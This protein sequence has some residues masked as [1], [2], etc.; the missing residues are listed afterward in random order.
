MDGH[1]IKQTWAEQTAGSGHPSKTSCT[2]SPA[3]A[4]SPRDSGVTDG[5][6]DELWVGGG[7]TGEVESVT[8]WE[9]SR[10]KVKL[11]DRETAEQT[12]K[13]NEKRGE[14]QRRFVD[15]GCRNDRWAHRPHRWGRSRPSPYKHMDSIY[16]IFLYEQAT[17]MQGNS[18]G[19]LVPN[20]RGG[21]IF[22][23]VVC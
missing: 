5:G 13:K 12:E 1:V 16:F 22:L 20:P 15:F 3:P 18:V 21:S 6:P 19:V 17:W 8:G 11:E 10:W 4:R 2:V 23:P 7:G 9:M 14:T